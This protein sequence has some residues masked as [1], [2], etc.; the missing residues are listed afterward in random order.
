MLVITL[1]VIPLLLLVRPPPKRGGPT[2]SE[3]VALE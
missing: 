1:A 3:P 2:P